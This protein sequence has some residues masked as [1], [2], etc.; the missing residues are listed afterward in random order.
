MLHLPETY[1]LIIY[2]QSK[3][4]I[5][6]RIG[7]TILILILIAVFA[8]QTIFD[9]QLRNFNAGLVIEDKY[10]E[11]QITNHNT[12]FSV[13]FPSQVQDYNSKVAKAIK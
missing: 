5:L 11:T 10:L 7:F 3:M 1:I 2:Q 9:L 13:E 8:F 4:K 6:K 12:F